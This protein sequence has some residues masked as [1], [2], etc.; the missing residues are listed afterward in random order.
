MRSTPRIAVVAS[1]AALSLFVV[2][3]I[4]LRVVYTHTSVHTAIAWNLFLAWIPL[5]LALVTSGRVERGRLGPLTAALA[6]LWLV[7]LPNAPYVVTDLKYIGASDDV[8]ILYDV[9]LLSAAAWTA[10]LLGLISILLVHVA[11][12]R[13]V[14]GKVAWAFVVGVS[15]SSA[16]GIYLGRVR[17][18]NSWDLLV[19]PQ[20]FLRE[21][22]NAVLHPISDARPLAMTALFAV[23]LV[24]AYLVVYSLAMSVLPASAAVAE[25][26]RSDDGVRRPRLLLLITLAET[27]GAQTYVALLLPALTP[28][29]DVTVAAHGP[30]PVHDAAIAAGARFASLEHVR[31]PINPARDLRG[32]VELVSLFR[33]ERPDIVHANSSKAGVLGRVAAAL[34]GV[35]IRVF[36][37]HG[38]AFAAYEGF[39]GRLY[40]WADRLMRPLT[41]VVVCVARAERELGILARTCTPERSVVI[42]TAVDV[43]GFPTANH[44]SAPPRIV[45]VGRFAYPKDHATLIEALAAVEVEYDA[46]LV[47]DGPLRA[48]VADDLRR[49]D[50]DHHVA[51]LGER[52]DVPRLLATC[53][54]FIL[55]SRSE[56]LPISVLEA[57]AARLPVVA[58]NVGGL[59]EL[60][61]DGITGFLVPPAD[62]TALAEAVSRLL[63]D[64]ELRR[65]L[66]DA[67]RQRVEE[68]FDLARF[69]DAHVELYRRQLAMRGLPSPAEPRG[70]RSSAPV[71]RHPVPGTIHVPVRRARA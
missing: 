36:T 58:T 5:G 34:A 55:S 20:D 62:S 50:L 56:G 66:G 37:V 25:R 46:L 35:P 26:A 18:W 47:G 54:V 39:A 42:H 51:L 64:P 65:R 14:A 23:F 7:F 13:F 71:A 33:R 52:R 48:R 38:W 15:A 41:T 4:L 61:V 30:G 9:L 12:R 27:G 11:A 40:L 44:P 24:A 31:R 3:T 17:R 10:L 32:L 19:R 6:L 28:Q 21:V 16:F 70:A 49:L 60:V 57:M 68:R 29:F 67:A 22:E 59:S 2:A 45:S 43:A 63:A 8:P 1:L 69:H 53:D